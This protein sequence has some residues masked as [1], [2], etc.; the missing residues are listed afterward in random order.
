MS[1]SVQ[2]VLARAAD[3]ED[4]E[5]AALAD[6]TRGTPREWRQQLLAALDVVTGARNAGAQALAHALARDY[7]TR[8]DPGG[9]M[10]EPTPRQRIADYYDATDPAPR[11]ATPHRED[12]EMERL[13]TYRDTDP[14]RYRQL[15]ATTRLALGLY[16]DAK[17]RAEPQ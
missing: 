3:G 16:E 13:A 14:D 15:S 17:A 8:L 5:P 9:T 2:H 11:R 4:I 7:T 10:T 1:T 12:P 6:L